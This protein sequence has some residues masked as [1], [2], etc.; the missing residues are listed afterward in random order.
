M[1]SL[2]I[3]FSI[4]RRWPGFAS[5][6]PPPGGGVMSAVR[7]SLRAQFIALLAWQRRKR[8]E[9]TALFVAGVA[10]ALAIVLLPLPGYLSLAGLRWLMPLLLVLLL[11]PWFFYR[12][13]WRD[14][15]SLRAL[16]ELDKTLKLA[17]RATTAWELSAHEST[18]AA[19]ELVFKQAHERLH[20][21][22]PPGQFP[23]QWHWQS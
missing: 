13:R 21:F 19:H 18:R 14:P 11:A 1:G 16:L 8:L 9:E 10:L 2:Y 20:R 12:W 3:L 15:D 22:D 6:G 17:E 23:R 5:L 4:R 7:E